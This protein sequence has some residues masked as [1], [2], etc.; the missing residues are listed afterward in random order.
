MVAAQSSGVSTTSSASDASRI[1][2]LHLA[3]SRSAAVRLAPVADALESSQ[4]FLDPT[5][6][7]GQAPRGAPRTAG[8]WLTGAAVTRA[9]EVAV[10]RFR[11]AV[12]LIAGDG[13][14]AL[15]AA[16]AASRQGVAIA[17]VG[18][19][20]RCEDRAVA[21]EINRIVLDELATRHY[22]DGEEAAER[23]R[24][25]GVPAEAIAI[26]GSTVPAVVARWLDSVRERATWIRLGLDR[27]E[28]VLAMLHKAEIVGDDERVARITEE[29]S[30]LALR[31]PV[32]LVLDPAMRG[33]M[34]PMGDI[35]RLRSAGAI[36]TGPL[37]Y[38]D[39]LSLQ[40]GAGAVLTDSAAVQEETTVLGVPC[41][42]PARSSER[43]LTLTRGTNVLLGDDPMAI[44][45]VA[46][47]SDANATGPI[48]LWDA[49]AG[50]RIAA[51]LTATSWECT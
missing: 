12:A 4:L 2:A 45:D 39:S 19:G 31:V 43:T 10:D 42:T 14:T 44:A 26:V 35:T 46:A 18:A 15:A 6:R 37:E 16:L 8:P 11:P 22:V 47:G 9:V 20:L 27:G 28:Y 34:G 38:L 17:R 48:P 33:M 24:A 51:D 41:F 30:A 21:S 7:L 3:V 32:V 29:L 49:A 25:E 5:G 36:I 40:V 50:R 1:H 23:L 13:D